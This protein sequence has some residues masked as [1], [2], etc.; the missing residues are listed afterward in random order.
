MKKLLIF[1]ISVFLT[2]SCTFALNINQDDKNKINLAISMVDKS[3]SKQWYEYKIEKLESIYQKIKIANQF[4]TQTQNK[5]KLLYLEQQLN[6]KIQEIKENWNIEEIDPLELDLKSYKWIDSSLEYLDSSIDWDTFRN[7]WLSWQNEER[8]DLW[9]APFILSDKLNRSAAI[10]AEYLSENNLTKWL[11]KR[12]STDWYY[13]FDNIYSWFKWLGIDF[14]RIDGAPF[15]EN[16]GYW[17]IKCSSNCTSSLITATKK[18][19]NYFMSE[20]SYN[21]AHYRAISHNLFQEVGVSAVVRN[22]RYYVV[23]HYGTEVV[24]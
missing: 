22:N 14:E 13:N 8:E 4:L 2:I 21:G 15:T 23:I 16:I 24:D 1:I 12:K 19:F 3:L 9:L 10:W 18:S 6:E 7:S 11:H 5:D 17:M 20:K